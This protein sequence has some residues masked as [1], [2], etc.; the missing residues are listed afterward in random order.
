MQW[1]P[2]FRIGGRFAEKLKTREVEDKLKYLVLHYVFLGA[3]ISLKPPCATPLASL[4]S[5][6]PK[7]REYHCSLITAMQLIV[8]LISK[9]SS[10]SNPVGIFIIII[11]Q[12]RRTATECRW[13][14]G[15]LSRKKIKHKMKKSRRYR[16]QAKIMND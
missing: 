13:G 12:R 10:L 14:G 7:E 1:I 11:K 15:F 3:W 9:E 16:I 6:V 4:T 5:N 2:S 8:D